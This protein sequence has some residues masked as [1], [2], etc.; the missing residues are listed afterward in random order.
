MYLIF[1][2]QLDEIILIFVVEWT[3]WSVIISGY[4]PLQK[5]NITYVYLLS[6]FDSMLIIFRQF[7]NKKQRLWVSLGNDSYRIEWLP[8]L[9][10]FIGATNFWMF[11]QFYVPHF[12]R[13]KERFVRRPICLFVKFLHIFYFFSECFFF[14]WYYNFIWIKSCWG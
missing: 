7:E 11:E 9:D 14:I 6:P 5:K 1:W 10:L 2:H 8:K 13:V 12:L 4:E 3:P